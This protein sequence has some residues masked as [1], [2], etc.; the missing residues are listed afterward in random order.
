[1]TEMR[2]AAL[3]REVRAQTVHGHEPFLSRINWRRL[4]KKL[5]QPPCTPQLNGPMDTSAYTLLSSPPYHANEFRKDLTP[6][7]QALFKEW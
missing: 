4:E 5:L 6:K 7:V 1:M 2:R 3:N